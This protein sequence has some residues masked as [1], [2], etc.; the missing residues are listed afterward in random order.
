MRLV[1]RRNYSSPGHA[2][3]D[4]QLPPPDPSL[5]LTPSAFLE[6]VAARIDR[7]HDAD[8]TPILL[9]GVPMKAGAGKVYSG[10]IYADIRDPRTNDTITARI[11][12][13][14]VDAIEWG[15]EAVFLGL[16]H[17]TARRGELRPEFRVNSVQAGGELRLAS[18]D[19]LMER[20][21]GAIARLK[22][23]VRAALQGEWPRVV[24]V[25]G[26]GS[27]AVD[28]IRAQLR[29]AEAELEL[30]VV[31]VSMHEPA[32]VAQPLRQ[33]TDAQAVVLTRGG[34]QTVHGLEWG[35]DRALAA[36]PVPVLAALGHATERSAR[37]RVDGLDGENYA[38]PLG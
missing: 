14:L 32:A 27:V 38:T 9:R 6:A 12:E 3:P 17:F 4:E 20:W 22:R 25:T 33:A 36:S 13:G 16:L 21:S 28:D 10:F 37:P 15:R 30:Q 24:V 19:E 2:M 35:V 1:H 5:P 23:D 29:E 7:L 26:V 11:P 8:A 34:G 31:R 18:K